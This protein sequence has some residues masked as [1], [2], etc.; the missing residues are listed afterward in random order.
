MNSSLSTKFRR[1]MVH[2]SD[3]SPQKLKPGRALYTVYVSGTR[4]AVAPPFAASDKNM[5]AD[6][7]CCPRVIVP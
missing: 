6:E 2:E 5:N 3:H 1:V 4:Q 7:Y